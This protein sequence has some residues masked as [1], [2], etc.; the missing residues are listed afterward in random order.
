MSRARVSAG[1]ELFLCEEPDWE[2]V[3]CSGSGEELSVKQSLLDGEPLL[4][5][6]KVI[7]AVSD[8]DE[9][10][11][12]KLDVLYGPESCSSLIESDISLSELSDA[13]L[14]VNN[15]C[16]AVVSGTGLCESE[17]LGSGLSDE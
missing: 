4:L 8:S 15:S 7:S 11:W 9:S 13:C 5:S 10:E 12:D 14:S 3:T 6:L 17:F 2:N 1:T 16:K